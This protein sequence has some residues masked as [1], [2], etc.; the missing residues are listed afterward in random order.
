MRP[1]G[2]DTQRLKTVLRNGQTGDIDG[3]FP[4]EMAVVRGRDLLITELYSRENSGK[5]NERC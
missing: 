5:P 2:E 1:C 4:F 3:T